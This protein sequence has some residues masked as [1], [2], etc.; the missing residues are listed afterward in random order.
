[1]SVRQAERRLR[2]GLADLRVDECDGDG[3]ADHC[4][5]LALVRHACAGVFLRGEATAL[6]R[7]SRQVGHR[8]VESS[9]RPLANPFRTLYDDGGIMPRYI[10]Q[11]TIACLTRQALEALIAE[12]KRDPTVKCV[13]FVSDSLE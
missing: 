1:A 7:Q 9:S 5:G 12:L 13:R 8:A 10:S 11:H 4:P 2:C 3:G 6:Q